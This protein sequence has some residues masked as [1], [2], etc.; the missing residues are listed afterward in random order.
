[1][2][3]TGLWKKK[4]CLCYKLKAVCIGAGGGAGHSKREHYL[5][6]T[7]DRKCTARPSQSEIRKFIFL[8]F[9]AM[10]SVF[11]DNFL[12]IVTL[13]LEKKSLVISFCV[14]TAQYSYMA[15]LF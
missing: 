12:F 2:V 7:A 13:N 6:Q 1:M 8:R 15:T 14:I 11:S 4:V 5:Q 3:A 9:C 10:Y